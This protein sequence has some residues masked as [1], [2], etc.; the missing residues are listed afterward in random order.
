MKLFIVYKLLF[1]NNKVYI[2]QTCNFSARMTGHKNDSL[3]PNRLSKNCQVNNAIRKYGW[4]NVY[5][6]ILFL[7]TELDVDEKEIYYINFYNSSNRDF[8]YNR[9]GGGNKKKTVS[10][11]SRKLISNARSGKRTWGKSVLQLDLNNKI[12]KQFSCID[13]ASRETGASSTNISIMCNH[14]FKTCYLKGKKYISKP[15]S[16][17][18]FRWA[19]SNQVLTIA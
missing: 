15:K 8:G 16:V 10:I 14:K 5:K 11:E 19:F 9:E 3:N 1:P 17:G 2:G 6:E 12:I 7:G 18:G 4:D 13:E